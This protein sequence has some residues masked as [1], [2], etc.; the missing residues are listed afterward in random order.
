MAMDSPAQ[1]VATISPMIRR[2][3]YFAG[4]QAAGCLAYDHSNHMFVPADYGNDPVDEYKA[5]TERASL[6]DAAVERQIQI[7]GPE[8][9]RLADYLFTRDLTKMPI[10]SCRY[11]FV[12]W[13]NGVIITDTIVMRMASDCFWFSPTA[14]EVGLFAQ[15]VAH[16][17]NFD[18]SIREMD[19]S[20]MHLEGPRS[21]EIL[22]GLIGSDI[23]QLK[24][25]RWMNATVAGVDVFVSRTGYS[26]EL[27]YEVYA[28]YSGAMKAWD[29]I[30]AAGQAHELMVVTFVAAR[31]LEAGLYMIDYATNMYDEITPLHLW[32]AFVDFDGQDFVGKSAIE[33]SLA[34]GGPDQKQVGLVGTEAHIPP[35][36]QR[37]NLVR[38]GEVAGHTR[39][40]ARSPALG[41]NIAIAFVDREH[42]ERGT[43][44]NL[45]YPGG[46]EPMAVTDLP[47]VADRRRD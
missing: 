29:A 35:I 5:M 13:P 24:P 4:T 8:A 30:V 37:W 15:G 41:R 47:F 32:T 23:E 14:S 20:S 27:G 39:W 12:C 21:R 28:P 16:A 10:G 9:E 40:V 18:V 22:W 38:D 17:G 43:Q 44:L 6:Y 34:A 42:A 25:F 2:G 11:G 7:Q 46:S 33:A 19:Y 26:N 1:H 45:E 31:P 3:P 36:E